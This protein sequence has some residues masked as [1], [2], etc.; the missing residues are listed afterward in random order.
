MVQVGRG[1]RKTDLYLPDAQEEPGSTE[2]RFEMM[3]DT[4]GGIAQVR[5]AAHRSVHGSVTATYLVQC[6]KESW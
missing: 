6:D 4:A 5:R 3:P 2:D 1:K